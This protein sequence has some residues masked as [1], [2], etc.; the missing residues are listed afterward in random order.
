MTMEEIWKPIKGYDGI[1]EV[2]SLGR[3]RS[4]DRMVPAL[5]RQNGNIVDYFRKG[6]IIKQQP[7][8]NGEGY[9]VV[10][11]T[12]AD[13]K[14]KTCLV[15]RL[16][17][18]AF[19]PGYFDGADVNHKD[20]NPTNNTPDNLEWCDRQYNINYGTG[21]WRRHKFNARQVQQLTMDGKPVATFPTIAEAARKTGI[22]AS[23]IQCCLK[24]KRGQ[25]QAG[26]YR[27]KHIKV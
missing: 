19:V 1:Y 22:D 11:L 23:N 13:H 6:R 10:S 2:S 14:R 15:H 16:V 17:A 24:G 27:W 26:G 20:E 4:L 12:D 5:C 21:K 7:I 9:M 3:V 25:Y 8:N 18:T